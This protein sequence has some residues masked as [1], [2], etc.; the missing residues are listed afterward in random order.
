LIAVLQTASDLLRLPVTEIA[1]KSLEAR[2]WPDRCLGLPGDVCLEVITPGF[3]VVLGPPADG[4]A[5]R[6]DQQG[7]IRREPD[8]G[9]QSGELSVDF[10]RTGGLVGRPV[11]LHLSTATMPAAEAGELK[12]LVAEADFWNL[13]VGIDNGEPIVD[14]YSYSVGVTADGRNHD[15]NTYDGTRNGLA[16]YPGFGA[17]LGW[18][19]ER[20]LGPL[21]RLQR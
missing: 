8:G 20:A 12:R 16:S 2:D 10:V 15:V 18:L 7:K 14:G 4:V 19:A 21:E 6:T 13:P 5:W 9:P 11:E 3:R 17:L 1:V